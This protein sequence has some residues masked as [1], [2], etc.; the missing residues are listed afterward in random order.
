[1]GGV[2]VTI[3]LLDSGGSDHDITGEAFSVSLTRGRTLESEVFNA[4]GGSVRV[5]NYEANFNPAFLVDTSALLLE[6]GDFILLENG[7][8]L[9]LESGNGGAVG[10]YGDIELGR[11]IIINDGSTTVFTGHVEDF[12][13]EYDPEG[14]SEAVLSVRDGLGSLGA[15]SLREWTTTQ[16]MTGAR[17]SALLDRAEVAFPTGSSY[18]DIATGTQPLGEGIVSFGTNALQ[19]LQ[20]INRAENG[21]CFVSNIGKL[22]FQDRYGVFGV[23]P[24]ATFNGTVAYNPLT[25][26][27]FPISHIGVRFGTELLHFEVTVTRDGD[28]RVTVDE[29]GE[30]VNTVV[31]ADEQVSRN[32]A[33]I[34]GYPTL[35]ARNLTVGPLPYNSD[36][37]GFGLAEFLRERY[38]AFAAQI[39]EMTVPLG[40]LSTAHR[41]TVCALDIGDVV[42]VIWQPYGTTGA[43]TQ[44]VAIEGIQYEASASKGAGGKTADAS[45]TFLL[46]NARDPGYFQV[47]TDAVGG[48]KLVAP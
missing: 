5:R 37:H 43:V 27:V 29:D 15:T 41:A 23:T 19:E 47:G 44:T 45:M 18:R 25:S 6:S 26:S 42:E 32:D 40:R 1:M 22:T 11:V 34:A 24:V 38:E 10:T 35:G 20:R 3:L 13:Y 9:L 12:D 8:R 21:R 33:L 2:S 36:D 48:L 46:S 30:T 17:V 28:L 4:G 39:S 14:R 16:Q 7:D 31:P